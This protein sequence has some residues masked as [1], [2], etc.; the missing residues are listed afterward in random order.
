L[1]SAVVPVLASLLTSARTWWWTGNLTWWRADPF[2]GPHEPIAWLVGGLLVAALLGWVFVRSSSRAVRLLVGLGGLAQVAFGSLALLDWSVQRSSWS[3]EPLELPLVDLVGF[4]VAALAAIVV[5]A[6]LSSVHGRREATATAALAAALTAL[7]VAPSIVRSVENAWPQD[8]PAFELRFVKAV[9]IYDLEATGI[10]ATETDCP[11]VADVHGSRI[12]MSRNEAEQQTSCESLVESYGVRFCLHHDDALVLTQADI[13]RVR[14]EPAEAR[15]SFTLFLNRAATA[16]LR[17][18]SL[19]RDREH[20][21]DPPYDAL[22]IDGE[23]A[24]VPQWNVVVLDGAFSIHAGTS[25]ST[26]VRD[27]YQ[28]LTGHEPPV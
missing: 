25:A 21:G 24:L 15:G 20:P 8:L 23:L 3:P 19:R 26:D 12:C 14:W 7:A 10:V 13:R 27:L 5:A 9:P 17:D 22:L 28:T 6:G 4:G 2:F 16:Q 11:F 18:R 1:A